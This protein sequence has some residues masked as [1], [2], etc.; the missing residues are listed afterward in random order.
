VNA[1][2]GWFEVLFDDAGD[3]GP[4][5]P[6]AFRS[7]YG[8]WRLP[9][10]P[11]TYVFV[12]FVSA[13]DGR[14]SFAEPGHAGGG[15]VSGF[16]AR[17][18]WLMGLLRAR[19]DA[20]LVGDGTM[21]AE[22]DHVWTAEFISPDEAEALAGLRRD[23]GRSTYPLQVVLSLTGE[24]PADAAVFQHAGLELVIATT[25]A[26]APAARRT[27]ASVLELGESV[28]DVGALV[29]ELGRRG[30]RTLLCEGGPRVYGSLLAAGVPLDEFLTLSPLLLGDGEPG[31][32]RPSLVEGARFAPGS[33]PR[34]RLLGLR[35]GGDH[36]YLRSRYG[37]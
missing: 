23:E 17:D 37:A 15:D 31:P 36:L 1:P 11:S 28:V 2:A 9:R 6:D 30:I 34:S 10:E 20:V 16:D 7:V 33:A 24:L 13:R 35:R 25:A 22:P 3:G 8:E 29:N 27:G 12:N 21:W 4:G 14:V 32:P 26:G 5:L 18:R 19:A